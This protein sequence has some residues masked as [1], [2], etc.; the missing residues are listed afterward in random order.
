[1]WPS[2]TTYTM[3][4]HYVTFC[5]SDIITMINRSTLWIFERKIF[6]FGGLSNFFRIN[7]RNVVVQHCV[8]LELTSS[9]IE[10]WRHK[11]STLYL[12]L[13]LSIK[14]RVKQWTVSFRQ[15]LVE[16]SWPYNRML[17]IVPGQKWKDLRTTLSPT[18]SA[19]KMKQVCMYLL[20]IL[21]VY[22]KTFRYWHE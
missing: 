20:N 18:F 11:C 7:I 5:G 8:F 6:Y 4:N 21:S 15:G 16:F 3:L 12:F 14:V 9:S 1:M 17:T 2:K 13:T 22:N 19:L 10:A